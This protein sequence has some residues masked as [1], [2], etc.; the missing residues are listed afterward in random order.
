MSSIVEKSNVLSS[1]LKNSSFPKKKRKE[2]KKFFVP[3]VAKVSKPTLHIHLNQFE[4][5]NDRCTQI[6]RK[7]AV[8][9]KQILFE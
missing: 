9:C 3:R 2:K 4:R 7:I 8:A 5:R 1:I 6:E